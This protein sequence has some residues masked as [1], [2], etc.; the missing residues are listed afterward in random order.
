MSIR[1]RDK[2]I[3][4]RLS[5]Q[6]YERLREVRVTRGARSISELARD[7]VSQLVGSLAPASDEALEVRVNQLEG[8]IRGLAL[9]I[10]KLKQASSAK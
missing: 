5:E 3:S 9:E 1:S 10:G 8:Q 4:F 6:A 7:A 2:M